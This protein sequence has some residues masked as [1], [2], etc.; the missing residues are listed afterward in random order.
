[1]SESTYLTNPSAT[2]KKKKKKKKKVKINRKE[3]QLRNGWIPKGI[4]LANTPTRRPG[5]HK[6][7]RRK[8]RRKKQKKQKQSK[9]C[10][11]GRCGMKV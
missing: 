2:S 7:E 1:V 9:W 8:E 10:I 3:G 11:T 5:C 6:K 4:I